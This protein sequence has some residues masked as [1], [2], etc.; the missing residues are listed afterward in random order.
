MADIIS[1]LDATNTP[2]NLPKK[3]GPV[4]PNLL[5]NMQAMVQER[6]MADPKNM[7]FSGPNYNTVMSSLKDAAAWASG[8]VNGPTSG[9]AARDREKSLE[10]QQLYDMRTKIATMQAAQERQK[11]AAEVLGL[12]APAQPGIEGQIGVQP[13]G[14]APAQSAGA[15]QAQPGAAPQPAG[16]TAPYQ[17]MMSSLPPALQPLAKMAL[18]EGDFEAF[19]NI[20]KENVKARPDMQ[21]NYEYAQT[22]PA[23]QKEVYLRTIQKEGYAPQTY[24]GDDGQTYQFTPVGA[25]P[26][27]AGGVPGLT[28]P[29]AVAAGPRP[30]G[31]IQPSDIGYVES[32]GKSFAQGPEVPGQGTAKSSMQVMD[33]TS[34][35]PGYGVRPAQ[36]TGDKVKDEAERVRVGEDY[37]TALKK[38]YNNNSS[39]AAA[40]YVWGPGKVDA[41]MKSGAKLEDLPTNV[42]TYVADAHLTG[43]VPRGTP[44]NAAA[45]KPTATQPAVEA[46]IPQPAA[47]KSV[48]QIAAEKAGETRRREKTAEADVDTTKAI[49]DIGRNAGEKS[50]RL[51]DAARIVNDP[52]MK[53]MFGVLERG[54]VL[55]PITK[56]VAG[57]IQ[58]GTL[59]SLK[60][61]EMEGALRNAGATDTQIAN[62]H[63]IETVLKQQELEYAKTYLKGQGAVSDNERNI[64]K[65]AIGSIQQPAEQLRLMVNIMQER[66]AFDN[67]MYQE[68]NAYRKAVKDPYASFEK[69]TVDSPAADRL[70][71]EHNQAL[72]R[73]LKVDAGAFNDPFNKDIATR[74]DKQ[75]GGGVTYRKVQ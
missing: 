65:Q 64:V 69:F 57:G 4:D 38:N 5:Q 1:G 48:E 62:V 53:D 52:T 12:G 33:A 60:F 13:V 68:F 10:A 49:L 71:T 63:R 15:M 47:R 67:K 8:G 61:G 17:Q 45:T 9:L 51:T 19:G 73:T 43:A 6:S 27:E 72:A 36:I 32:R 39:L 16:G 11:R 46:A 30:G 23:D 7:I 75:T 55:G 74:S 21:K 25:R 24:I 31:E 26:K 58:M 40:A 35:N 18:A 37:F 44:I 3:G 66:A 22:L 54:G 29:P 28:P 34:L 42:K 2:V 56:F 50:I 70:I 14:G 20:I 41:W 59:G